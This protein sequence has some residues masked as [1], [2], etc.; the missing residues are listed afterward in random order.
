MIVERIA[1][2]VENKVLEGI[3]DVRDESDRDGIR[4]AI[5]LKKDGNPHI[6]MNK[7]YKNALLQSTFSGNFVVLG[8]EGTQPKRLN[9]LE[10]LSS[11][12]EFR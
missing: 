4:V 3:S 1:N 11:F 9:L 2:L 10:I 7:L 8:D 12:I 5:D 6:I